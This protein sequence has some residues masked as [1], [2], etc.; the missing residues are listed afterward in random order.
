M[1]PA[2]SSERVIVYMYRNGESAYNVN[3][4]DDETVAYYTKGREEAATVRI[5]C[6]I[7]LKSAN[8][9]KVPC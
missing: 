2:A 1:W 9:W 6:K 4:N 3:N 8:L 5:V 7:F